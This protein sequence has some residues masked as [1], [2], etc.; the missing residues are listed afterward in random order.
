MQGS[1]DRLLRIERALDD[2]RFAH[3]VLT[4]Q[5]DV[6]EW[7]GPARSAFDAALS[8][9]PGVVGFAESVLDRERERTLLLLA[10]GG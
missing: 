3:A 8:E 2:V 7:R 4:E 10:A 5:V 1:V 6:G 9:L